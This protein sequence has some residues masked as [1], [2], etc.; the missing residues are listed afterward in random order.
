MWF[1]SIKVGSPCKSNAYKEMKKTK[2]KEMYMVR[3]ADDLEFLV[4]T[5]KVA[6]K[7]KI[8]ITQWIEQRLKLEVSQEKTRIVNVRK[9]YSDFLGFKIKMIPRRKKLVVKSHI[10]D[11]QFKTQKTSW[12]HRQRKLLL[13]QREKQN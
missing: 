7:T 13:P 6:E 5:K 8:A 10:S 12:Y 1:I 4:A 11:K 3:Y 2:L 9:R